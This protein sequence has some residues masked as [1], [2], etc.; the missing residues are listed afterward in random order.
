MGTAKPTRHC[1][2]G[3]GDGRVDADDARLAVGQRAA[4]IARVDRGVGLDEILEAVAA[5]AG[6]AEGAHDAGRDRVLQAERVSDRD[7]E[8]ADL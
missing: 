2:P 7:D 4:G 8:V 1:H 3:A 5:D 6:A